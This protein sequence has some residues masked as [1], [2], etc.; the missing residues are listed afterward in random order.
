MSKKKKKKKNVHY[1]L[2]R[3]WMKSVPGFNVLPEYPAD[4]MLRGQDLENIST[5]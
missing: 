2:K 5:N 1:A 3:N 4:T